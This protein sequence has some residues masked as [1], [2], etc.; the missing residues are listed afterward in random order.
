[1]FLM[2]QTL[3][4]DMT[5][6]IAIIME[7]SSQ[8]LSLSFSRDHEMRADEVGFTHLVEAGI[9]P[10]GLTQFFERLKQKESGTQKKYQDYLQFIS[11]HPMTQDRIDKNKLRYEELSY[12]IKNNILKQ[13]FNYKDFKTL[14]K[15]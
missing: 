3:L 9:D 11:T 2:V 5:G 1:L 6:V 15:Q 13:Q 10:R 7:N 4:G 12:D 14:L 8:L